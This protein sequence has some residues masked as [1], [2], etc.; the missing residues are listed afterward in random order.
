MSLYEESQE[1]G[2]PYREK[3]L[4]QFEVWLDRQFEAAA[5]RRASYFA[6]D[7]R[8]AEAYAASL[9]PYR[10]HFRAMLGWPLTL[11]R[12][13]NA[14]AAKTVQVATD[15]LGRIERVWIELFPDLWLYGLLFVP[16]GSERRPLILSQH[17]GSGT[18]ELTAGFFGSANYNDMTRRALRRGAA[19][20]APQLFRWNERFGRPADVV[21]LDRQMRQLGGSL[22]AF[23]LHA[24]QRVVDY[25]VTRDEV[26]PERIGMVGL[27]YGGFF[28]LYM[29]AAD[30][31]IRAA[32]SSC[33]FNDRRRY[34]RRDWGYRNAANTF[35]D[36]E[37]AGLI[38][39]RALYVEVAE[40]D[41]L[42][43]V[44]YARQQVPI[45]EAL[46]SKLGI[47]QR[48]AYH[49]H[50]GRHEFDRDDLGLDFLSRHLG[51]TT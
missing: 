44:A 23:E 35:F 39:P 3:F 27:S 24:L 15:D 50:S 26:D 33:F 32:L 38:C 14:P 5:A 43:D 20:F 42:L 29:A 22:A 51:L 10:E 13:A 36:P 47:P 30:T 11:P 41:E 49:E 25:L 46:Y 45:V 40:H 4:S 7:M 18:P 34:G 17:G 28:T 9:V 8:S 21:E 6:P 48:F 16:P 31:R 19:V 12:P 37:V 1:A 2:A